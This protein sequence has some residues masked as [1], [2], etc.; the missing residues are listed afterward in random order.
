[1]CQKAHR[2]IKNKNSDLK[3]TDVLV[4]SWACL[5]DNI[6]FRE[7]LLFPAA[8]T[9]VVANCTQSPPLTGLG[10]YFSKSST[11]TWRGSVVSI[12]CGMVTKRLHWKRVLNERASRTLFDNS[13]TVPLM[14]NSKYPYMAMMNEKVRELQ[15][16]WRESDLDNIESFQRRESLTFVPNSTE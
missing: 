10:Q 9:R 3:Q 4:D 6:R 1:M 11:L 7:K 5:S 13:F 16:N 12:W 14:K 8:N 15:I 2:H